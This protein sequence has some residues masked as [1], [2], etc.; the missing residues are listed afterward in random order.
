M[1]MAQRH[2]FGI[3]G[4]LR[5]TGSATLYV[6]DE[7][8]QVVR[9]ITPLGTATTFAGRVPQGIFNPCAGSADGGG[10]AA[11]FNRPH[12][13]VADAAGNV[14]IAD[15]ENHTVRKM[16]PTGTVTTLAGSP[17]SAGNSDGVGANARFSR[18]EGITVDGTGNVF[19]ADTGNRTIR[20]I[21][22]AGV[23]T[24][25]PGT[26]GLLSSSLTSDTA[27]NVYAQDLFNA[28]IRKIAPDGTVSTLASGLGLSAGDPIPGGIAADS[29]GNV[30]VAH[31]KYDPS[32]GFKGNY[33]FVIGKV[34]AAGVYSQLAG[35]PAAPKQFS[36]PQGLAVDKT[37]NVY[38]A[39]PGNYSILRITPSGTVTTIAGQPSWAMTIDGQ[40]GTVGTKLG[41]F[42]GS[43]TFPSG[44]AVV[45]DSADAKLLVVD[46]DAILSATLSP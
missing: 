37:G 19:L 40:P 21:T 14:Y 7:G 22:P 28:S 42:P 23:V 2:H 8:N 5:S 3:R 18:P 16:S 41:P 24:T 25:L 36:N 11:R 35:D 32:G 44:L 29:A 27:G 4:E 17:G 12:A 34:T 43:L 9:R 1:G 10:F 31:Q 15:T 45:G 30:Y 38:V 39:E 20:K 6:A 46:M 33:Y 26:Q 13:L